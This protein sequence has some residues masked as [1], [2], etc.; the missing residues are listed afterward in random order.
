MNKNF[1]NYMDKSN[2]FINVMIAIALTL[3]N[4]L[5]TFRKFNEKRLTLQLLLNNYTSTILCNIVY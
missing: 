2:V 3:N 5:S 4:I 1:F